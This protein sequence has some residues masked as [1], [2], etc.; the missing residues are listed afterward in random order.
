M[1]IFARPL[2]LLLLFTVLYLAPEARAEHVVI[3]SGTVFHLNPVLRVFPGYTFDFAGEG[4]SARGTDE[5]LG[6]AGQSLSCLAC[7]PGQTLAAT[8]RITQFTTSYFGS[9][10]YNGM[11]Y[12]PVWFNGSRFD[13]AIAPVEI[14]FDTPDTFTLTSAFTLSGTLAGATFPPPTPIFSMTLS[15][16]GIATITMSRININGI[17]GYGIN[18]VSYT[19]QPAAVPEPATLLLLGTGLAGVA[20]RM[21]RKRRKASGRSANADAA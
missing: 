19:F 2:P 18:S 21:R 13:L 15:G 5:K 9:A 11:S 10:T 8:F 7:A 20:E 17:I 3:T 4:I 14:P 16:Q 1:R 6:G 12:A